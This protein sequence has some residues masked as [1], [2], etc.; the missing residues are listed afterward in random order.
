[1]ERILHCSHSKGQYIKYGFTLVELSIVLVIIGLVIGGIVFG[2]DM[3]RMSEIRA[4]IVQVEQFKAASNAFKL[5]YNC[6]AGDCANATSFLSGTADGNGNKIIDGGAARYNDTESNLF[7]QH[8]ALAGFIQGSYTPTI[9]GATY[10]ADINFPSSKLGGGFGAWNLQAYAGGGLVGSGKLFPA[11]YGNNFLLGTPW[12]DSSA[13]M[14]LRPVMSGFDARRIDGKYD[15]GLPAY[16][17]IVTWENTSG[18]SFSCASTDVASTA[19]YNDTTNYSTSI[20]CGLF[21]LNAF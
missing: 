5:K 20:K 6:I 1:M 21:F 4:T 9:S 13:R 2:R 7:W 10:Q 18:Y 11:Q 12:T 15:D 16:G 19:V 14:P 3:I 17:S 8:L